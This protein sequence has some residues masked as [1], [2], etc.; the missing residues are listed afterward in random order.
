[1]AAAAPLNGLVASPTLGE[2]AKAVIFRHK[3]WDG[4]LAVDCHD[5]GMDALI[6]S[7][8]D[9]NAEMAGSAAVEQLPEVAPRSEPK[10]TPL[11][12]PSSVTAPCGR[13]LPPNNQEDARRQLAFRWPFAPPTP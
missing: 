8:C 12:R 11:R 3:I 4:L 1:M 13:A 9:F 2:L 5:D 7:R 6:L 10:Y